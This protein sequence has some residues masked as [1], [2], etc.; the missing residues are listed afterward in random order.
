MDPASILAVTVPIFVP[1]IT[2][3]GFDPL[4]FGILFMINC[5]LATLTPPVGLNLFVLL[6]IVPKEITIMDIFK[7]CLPFLLLHTLT[8]VIVG[9]VPQSALWLPDVMRGG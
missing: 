2:A 6:G 9:I 4:W 3:L 1:V 5:E 7:G 8:M